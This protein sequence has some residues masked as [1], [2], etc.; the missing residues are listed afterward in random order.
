MVLRRIEVLSLAESMSRYLQSTLHG[1][2]IPD[3]SVRADTTIPN[4]PP[5]L[6][7]AL[8]AR[9]ARQVDGER[10]ARFG[11]RGLQDEISAHR[12]AE[13]A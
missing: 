10:R 1:P 12:A 8:V 13:L 5:V 7:L 4:V 2:P 6:S 3:S 11:S 9:F